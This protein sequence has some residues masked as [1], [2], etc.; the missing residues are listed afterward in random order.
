MHVDWMRTFAECHNQ[1]FVVAIVSHNHT[2]PA[3]MHDHTSELV[4]NN[5]KNT[6][7]QGWVG[8]TAVQG[9]QGATARCT[10]WLQ[11]YI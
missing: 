9:R 6:G 8:L 10:D 5:N 3:H 1:M 11:L 4:E 7:K 2:H